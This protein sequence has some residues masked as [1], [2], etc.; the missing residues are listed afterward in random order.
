MTGP[1][2]GPWRIE[3][4]E[5]GEEYWF[6]GGCYEIQSAD[7]WPICVWGLNDPQAEANARLIA[8]APDLLAAAEAV[9][10]FQAGL[11]TGDWATV[12]MLVR[13]AISKVRS[14]EVAS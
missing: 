9:V 4:N 10:A 13:E 7:G 11:D 14:E 3:R 8:S 5:E 2:P 1:L 12:L 6:R